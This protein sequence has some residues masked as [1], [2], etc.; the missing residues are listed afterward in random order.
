MN[1]LGSL[2]RVETVQLQV[3]GENLTEYGGVPTIAL[4]PDYTLERMTAGTVETA[5]ST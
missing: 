2:E 5:G 1:T 3:E 4:K